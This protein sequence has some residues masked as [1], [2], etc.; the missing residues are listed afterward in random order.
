VSNPENGDRLAHS[1]GERLLLTST[2]NPLVKQFRRLHNAKERQQEQL[3]LLEGTHLIQEAVATGYPLQT[4][5]ATPAWQATHLELWSVIAAERLEL[6]TDKV[7]A[8]MATTVNPDGVL[9]IVPRRTT[10]PPPLSGNLVLVIDRLQDPGNLG[11]LMRTAVAA[12]VDGLWVSEDSVALDHPKVLRASAGQWFRL[13]MATSDDLLTVVKNYQQQGVQVVATGMT[14][15]ADY[16]QVDFTRPT[17]ILLGNEGSGL[18]SALLAQSDR[19]VRVPMQ[20]GVE[21]LNVSITAAL[22]LYEVQRQKQ[23]QQCQL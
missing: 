21:S 18:S 6:V 17:L 23:S 1:G 12:G 11:T 15:A 5:C 9:A 7:L 19:V 13:A 22:I 3:F 8:A 16:W 10:N 14:A 20:P 2:Q 4:L